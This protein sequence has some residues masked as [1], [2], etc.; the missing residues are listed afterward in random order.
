MVACAFRQIKKFQKSSKVY[1]QKRISSSDHLNVI[2]RNI[3]INFDYIIAK[4]M[5]I[6]GDHKAILRLRACLSI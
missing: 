1:F 3:N 2:K 5:R 6:N 4:T